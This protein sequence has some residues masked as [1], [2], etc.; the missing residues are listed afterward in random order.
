MIEIVITANG[1]IDLFSQE[2]CLFFRILYLFSNQD[3]KMWNSDLQ[4]INLK[5]QMIISILLSCKCNTVCLIWP[6]FTNLQLDEEKEKN[7][8]KEFEFDEEDEF[9]KMY[10]M[11]RLQ[12]MRKQAEKYVSSIR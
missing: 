7:A 10:H 6:W 1:E 12:E 5:Q 3:C 11:K 4:I 8:K 9:V 2:I